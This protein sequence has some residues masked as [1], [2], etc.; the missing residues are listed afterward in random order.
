MNYSELVQMYF[1]RSVA[2][3]WFWTIYVLVI[4]GV[5]GFSTF[6]QRPE[7][8]TTILVAVLYGCFA[9]KNLGAIEATAVERQAIL[10]AIRQYPESAA[11]AAA[12]KR[13]RPVVEPTMPNYD[14]AGAR[15]FHLV[16]DLLTIVFI[17]AKEWRRRKPELLLETRAN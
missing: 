13:V 7:L 10:S 6:R 11:D 14:V 4:G 1:E 5:V 9:Y 17:S 8:V 2:L 3:Q 15:T 12:V 16:C